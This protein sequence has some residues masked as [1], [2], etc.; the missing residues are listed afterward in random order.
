VKVKIKADNTDVTE[1]AQYK[2]TECGRCCRHSHALAVHKQSHSRDSVF[3]YATGGKLFSTSKKLAQSGIHR[4]EKAYICQLCGKAFSQS[5]RLRCHMRVHMAHKCSVCK[6]SFSRSTTLHN[7]ERYVHSNER[8]YQ[9]P[10]CGK[11]FKIIYELKP[12]VRIHTDAKP[13][14]CGHCTE[15]FRRFGQLKEHLLKSHDEG[16]WFTCDICQ[17]KFSQRGNLKSHLLRH[18]DVRP[19]VCSEC[20]KRFCSAAQLKHHRLAHSDLKQFCC[21]LCGKCFKYKTYVVSHFKRC[22]ETLGCSQFFPF[23]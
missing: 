1:H 18:A 17:K 9:C 8:P 14:S 20:P 21:V 10:F 22:S 19:Y 13:Y 12:H 4:E 15:R 5:G 23:E 2:C 11:Q 16:T 7:H 3:E 6:K